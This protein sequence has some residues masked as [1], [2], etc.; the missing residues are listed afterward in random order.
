MWRR[1][2]RGINMNVLAA[3]GFLAHDEHW[4]LPGYCE[5][6]AGGIA[7]NHSGHCNNSNKNS[8]RTTTTNDAAISNL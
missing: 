8:K 4:A 5:D 2:I 3:A 6:T 7:V 1:G